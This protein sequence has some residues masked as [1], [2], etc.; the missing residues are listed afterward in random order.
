VLLHLLEATA[1]AAAR[2]VIAMASARG[3]PC[4]AALVAVPLACA[5]EYTAPRTE[6]GHPDL[7][8]VWNTN[9]I[10]PLEARPDVP[11]LTLPKDEADAL[12][13]KVA[14]ELDE[15]AYF[16][17]DPEL[18]DMHQTAA[19]A[20]LGVVRGEYR[21]RQLVLPAN[22]M[23]PYTPEAR[24]ETTEVDHK[25]A[26][27]I[28]PPLKADGPEQRPSWERCLV[29]QGQPPIGM[30]TDY[31]PRRIVQTK[32]HVVIHTEYGDDVRIIPFAREH[33]PA[34]F[35]SALGDS[36]ARWEGETLVIET[37]RLPAQDRLRLFPTFLVPPDSTVVEKYTRVAKGELLYQYT[38]ID[39][40]V[41]TAP[42]LAEY[43]LSPADE[44]MFE[45]ACHEG[46]Y[47]LPWILQGA[48]EREKNAV[49]P[50]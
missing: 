20:G 8:G 22:G 26:T 30:V 9:F 11:M 5:A 14:N 36:I 3:I 48:R 41:Y 28:D 35:R 21:T 44:R 38:I 23:L 27:V 24:R 49:P 33:R 50:K 39:P 13:L 6:A 1:N 15:I 7:Q 10:L 4:L 34:I 37:V 2:G 40:A 29:A 47:S 45:F 17:F 19:S 12:A 16:Q 25:V 32:N 46:N 42:W 31:N 43:S 18:G